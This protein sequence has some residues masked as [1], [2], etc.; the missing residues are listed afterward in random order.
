MQL[1]PPVVHDVIS[2]IT[3]T[4]EPFRGTRNGFPINNVESSADSL[5]KAVF[6]IWAQLPNNLRS[7]SLRIWSRK[8]KQ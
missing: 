8:G 2:K 1:L 3:R 4:E 6:L 5:L 7:C